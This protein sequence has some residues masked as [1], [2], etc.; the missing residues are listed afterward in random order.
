MNTS[1]WKIL[2]IKSKLKIIKLRLNIVSCADDNDIMVFN[3]APNGM[4]W[5]TVLVLWDFLLFSSWK[6]IY[7][8][9][10]LNKLVPMRTD[11]EKLR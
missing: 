8:N 10:M 2:P 4:G 1:I 3:R 9:K 11:R 6:N 5:D 7:K